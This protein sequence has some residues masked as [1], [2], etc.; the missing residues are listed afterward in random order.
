MLLMEYSFPFDKLFTATTTVPLE[1]N[2]GMHKTSSGQIQIHIFR[3]KYALASLREFSR[4]GNAIIFI[5]SGPVIPNY[6]HA[7]AEL[8]SCTNREIEIYLM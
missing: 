2:R 1:W 3:Q 8:H 7:H 6:T 4:K 5:I